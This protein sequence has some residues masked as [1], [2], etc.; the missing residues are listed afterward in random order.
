MRRIFTIA[1]ILIVITSFSSCNK[2]TTNEINN[3]NDIKKI[4]TENSTDDD[5]SGNVMYDYRSYEELK[6]SDWYKQMLNKNSFKEIMEQNNF[7]IQ[8]Q[9]D[10][11]YPE[12]VELLYAE[13]NGENN[14]YDS[15]IFVNSLSNEAAA[16]LLGQME[17]GFLDENAEAGTLLY[18]YMD[19]KNR[20]SC[21]KIE[22]TDN[23]YI[24]NILINNI[25]LCAAS[26]EGEAGCIK[27]LKLLGYDKYIPEEKEFRVYK[28]V[29]G[30]PDFQLVQDN[31]KN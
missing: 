15:A 10:E 25:Y 8:T 11:Q 24:I 6:N 9:T 17:S 16:T 14:K 12:R 27:T 19:L 3:N 2:V 28:K 18:D 30:D 21:S 29:N 22:Y 20:F 23:N 4:E 5:S 26:K 1:M 31:K 7:I 13:K